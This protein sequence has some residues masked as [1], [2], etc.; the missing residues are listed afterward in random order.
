MNCWR[1]RPYIA[2]DT[3][4]DRTWLLTKAASPAGVSQPNNT[5]CPSTHTHLHR[6]DPHHSA[7]VLPCAP[8][9][10]ANNN[11]DLKTPDWA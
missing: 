7:A 2:A 1:V 5:L 9:H 4:T 6:I 10:A 8:H 3:R 11:V